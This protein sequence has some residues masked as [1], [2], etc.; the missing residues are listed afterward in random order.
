MFLANLVAGIGSLLANT[1][2]T[3]CWGW[4]Y[5]EPECPKELIK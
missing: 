5:D 4:L 3:L 1:S 2:S